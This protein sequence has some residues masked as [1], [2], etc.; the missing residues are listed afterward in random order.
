VEFSMVF[1]S[2]SVARMVL[3]LNVSVEIRTV[4]IGKPASFD[5]WGQREGKD[6]RGQHGG[7][8]VGMAAPFLACGRERNRRFSSGQRFAPPPSAADCPPED[9]RS[10]SLKRVLWSRAS[11]ARAWGGFG[12]VVG[13]TFLPKLSTLLE[14][15]EA[16]PDMLT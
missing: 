8:W 9:H 3:A 16:R 6:Q 4:R 5:R 14:A 12:G 13:M 11:P 7:P 10:L 15:V 2:V 1:L